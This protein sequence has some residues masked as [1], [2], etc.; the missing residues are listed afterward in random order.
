MGLLATITRNVLSSWMGFGVQVLSTLLLTPIIIEKVG[1]EAYGLWLFLGSAV[2]YYGLIDIGLRAGITQSITRQI[3]NKEVS[4]LRE[5]LS[6]YNPIMALVGVGVV[7]LAT[8][9]WQL[10]PHLVKISPDELK[11]LT[12]V[13]LI[14]SF[15]IGFGIAMLPYAAILVGL[16]R[17]DISEGCAVFSKIA[18]SLMI[19]I[20]LSLGGGI[21]TLAIAYTTGSMID[22]LLRFTFARTLLPE[23][24]K[25]A[26]SINGKETSSLVRNSYLNTVVLLSR[27]VIH[28]SSSII[29]GF[30]F[31]AAS[32]P[33]YSIAGSFVEYATKIIMLSTR[34][35][36][37]TMVALDKKGS[38]SQLLQL[39]KLS[40]K[41]AVAS[42]V[43][44]LIV[45]AVWMKR[46]LTLW[47]AGIEGADEIIKGTPSLFIILGSSTVAIA[48]QRCGSQ[49]LL[50]KDAVSV[51]AKLMALE[52][53]ATL[54]F[55]IGLGY[56]A[57][58]KGVAI[59]TLIPCILF[60]F[61]VYIPKHADLL[62]T[63]LSSLLSSVL[64]RPFIFGIAYL[65]TLKTFE[66]Y[67][68]E[69]GNWASFL[70]KAGG[71]SFFSFAI[72]SPILFTPLEKDSL[73]KLITSAFKKLSASTRWI[74]LPRK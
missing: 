5:K 1:L 51:L 27:Q 55:S 48:A 23:I 16:E 21:V 66:T 43:V 35:L 2:G 31:G 19:Y 14:Q 69:F 39:Y 26:W 6:T 10:I 41:L 67:L 7:V 47:F 36:F 30:L 44:I 57:G 58:L 20:G 46:F 40:T 38:E 28:F 17:Y 64:V 22:S 33:L 13:V 54:I 15:G 68:D 32:I 49:L 34:V 73:Y 29:V 74:R 59:G 71:L 53:I 12:T 9:A 25:V 70:F 11:N 50:A 52:A 3:A 18:S 72:L 61:L 45:G 62:N 42:S 60:S 24:K 56:L 63:N 8:S 37:P 4:G 65:I